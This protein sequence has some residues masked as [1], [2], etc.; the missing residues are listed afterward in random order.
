M[1]L[2]GVGSLVAVEEELLNLVVPTLA[3]VEGERPRRCT[4]AEEVVVW[5]WY[6]A[7]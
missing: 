6:V 2:V 1:G 3:V 5:T 7:R 4:Q